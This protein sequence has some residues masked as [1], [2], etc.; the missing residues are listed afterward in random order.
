MDGGNRKLF[1]CQRGDNLPLFLSPIS[2]PTL[3]QGKNPTHSSHPLRAN[4]RVFGTRP[5]YWLPGQLGHILGSS[6]T[7]WKE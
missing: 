2:S 4:Q 5:N 6:A 1:P 7:T 3:L